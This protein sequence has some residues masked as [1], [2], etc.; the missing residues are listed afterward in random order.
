M[1]TLIDKN[2]NKPITS[3]GLINNSVPCVELENT[4]NISTKES[5]N[6]MEFQQVNFAY[7]SRPEKIIIENFSIKIPFHKIICFEGESGIGKSTLVSLIV[8]LYKPTSGKII[9]NQFFF[10]KNNYD[11]SDKISKELFKLCDKIGVVEQNNGS[12]FSG[13]IAE[14]IAYGKV[15]F[16]NIYYFIIFCCFINYVYI[17]IS[18]PICN[19]KILAN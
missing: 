8:G 5:H 18:D 9:V 7:N 16:I 1:F 4:N 10:S 3:N 11:N 15:F 12:L 2:K 14:N 6:L 17:M 13:T 19:L